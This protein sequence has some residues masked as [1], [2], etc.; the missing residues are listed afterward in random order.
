MMFLE[1]AAGRKRGL[2]WDA[3]RDDDQGDKNIRTYDLTNLPIKGVQDNSYDGVYSEHFIEHLYKYQGINLFKEILRVLKPGGVVRTTWPSYDHVERLV[4]PEDLSDDPFVQYYYDRYCVR[5]HFQPNPKANRNKR[6]QE[7]VA[8]GLLHQKGEHLYIWGKD[9]MIDTLK[10]L[11]FTK[12]KHMGYGESSINEFQGI[13]SP[14]QIRSM[15]S[16][17]VEASKPW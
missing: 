2:N 3:I 14:N 8:L 13:D 16:T 15:H 12:V 1:L 5:E 4:G 7:Q 10:Q 17:V 11:G 9:E 6:K